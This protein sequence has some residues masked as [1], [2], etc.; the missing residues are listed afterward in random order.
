MVAFISSKN[1]CDYCTTAHSAF[2][3]KAFENPAWVQSIMENLGAAQVTPKL[4]TMLKFLEK[5]SLYPWEVSNQDI[6]NLRSAGLAD[7]AIEDAV[8]VCV[9][10]AI[11][12]RVADTLD[13]E[14]PKEQYLRRAVPFVLRFGYKAYIG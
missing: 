11:G 13:F 10:F 6:E 8:M 9:V 2:A 5:L 4:K 12:N 3:A 14:R 1:K 7:S